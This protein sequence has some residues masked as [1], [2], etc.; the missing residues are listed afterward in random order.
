[1]Q[2]VSFWSAMLGVAAG[3]HSSRLTFAET[4][5]LF[6]SNLESFIAIHYDM[7]VNHPPSSATM[8]CSSAFSHL[9]KV[10][11]PPLHIATPFVLQASYVYDQLF[12]TPRLHDSVIT[13][14]NQTLVDLAAEYI[15][16]GM[17]VHLYGCVLLSVMEVYVWM[18]AGNQAMYLSAANVTSGDNEYVFELIHSSP[19]LYNAFN[20]TNVLRYHSAI[21][22]LDANNDLT[23][24]RHVKRLSQSIVVRCV[25]L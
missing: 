8:V 3:G 25:T 14:V 16:A 2:E 5:A 4:N 6:S 21:S 1:M 22:A 15:A 17:H 18:T 20:H 7:V 24:V 11:L 13:L 19:V 23:Y 10:P 12:T 9:M